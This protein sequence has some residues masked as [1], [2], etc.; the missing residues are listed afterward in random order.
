MTFDAEFA[1]PIH[2]PH[3]LSSQIPTLEGAETFL[4]QWKPPTRMSDWHL[5]LQELS[6]GGPISQHGLEL[7][8]ERTQ[9]ETS[10]LSTRQVGWTLSWAEST[11][12]LTRKEQKKMKETKYT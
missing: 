4:S 8:T 6:W 2:S 5:G 12:L 7:V 10:R 1:E 3:H 11:L 9:K